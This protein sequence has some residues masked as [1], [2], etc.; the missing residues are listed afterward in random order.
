M[1]DI[2][3]KNFGASRIIY[4]CDLNLGFSKERAESGYWKTNHG[5]R[6]QPSALGMREEDC[7]NAARRARGR[8]RASQIIGKLGL[9]E[10][11]QKSGKPACRVFV[12]ALAHSRREFPS[13][14]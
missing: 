11:N 5:F 8:E 2:P 13:C 12:F 7:M 9:A 10:K 6:A 1:G 4:F 14:P 3:R